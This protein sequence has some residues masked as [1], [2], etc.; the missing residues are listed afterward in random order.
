MDTN[1][2]SETHQQQ[3]APAKSEYPSRLNQSKF[4]PASSSLAACSSVLLV[5]VHPVRDPTSSAIRDRGSLALGRRAKWASTSQSHCGLALPQAA[6]PLTHI[7]TRKV[8]MLGHTC[9]GFKSVIV[10]GIETPYEMHRLLPA[11]PAATCGL[12]S[13]ACQQSVRHLH[14]RRTPASYNRHRTSS[15]L[16]WPNKLHGDDE[17]CPFISRCPSSHM[18]AF[19]QGLILSIKCSEEIH[20]DN[21]LFLHAMKTK[22]KCYACTPNNLD[23]RIATVGHATRASTPKQ[24]HYQLIHPSPPTRCAMPDMPQLHQESSHKP[25]PPL[26]RQ[27]RHVLDAQFIIPNCKAPNNDS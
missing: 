22:S 2:T 20:I 4:Q 14:V 25:S 17:S 11:L 19:K 18:T 13:A 23:T 9:S 3:S 8:P 7:C 26:M 21:S 5:F 12:R 16:P 27:W 10:H 6:R 1:R 15:A 24:H